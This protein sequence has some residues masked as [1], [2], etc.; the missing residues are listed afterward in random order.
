MNYRT[1]DIRIQL[2]T[3]TFVGN[4]SN[5]V[6]YGSSFKGVAREYIR[7]QIEFEEVDHLTEEELF[8]TED[9]I[10]SL[11]V[12]DFRS[13]SKIDQKI[14]ITNKIGQADSIYHQNVIPKGTILEGQLI[15]KKNTSIS[16]FFTINFG[17]S[18]INH[19]GGKRANGYGQCN[20]KVD[21]F[22]TSKY[23]LHILSKKAS[24]WIRTNGFKRTIEYVEDEILNYFH[25][26]FQEIDALNGRDFEFLVKEIFIPIHAIDVNKVINLAE[27]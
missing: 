5:N 11:I 10:G 12:T 20:V 8:G 6:I 21:K 23:N 24:D 19:I 25:H 2:L 14:I 1:T 17:I 7:N 13:L 4:Q 18:D 26:N 3:D 9:K 16:S 15:Y 22:E 27:K